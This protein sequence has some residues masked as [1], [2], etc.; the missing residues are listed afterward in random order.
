MQAD[1]GVFAEVSAILD[2]IEQVL[3]EINRAE[4]MLK[5]YRAVPPVNTVNE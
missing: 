4:E 5:Q 2:E 1:T 3:I